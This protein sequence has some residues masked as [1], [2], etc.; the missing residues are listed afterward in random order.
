MDFGNLHFG[1]VTERLDLVADPVRSALP[2]GSADGV[3]GAEIDPE[4]A[5]TAAFCERYAVGMH[6][7]ANCV[8]IEAKRGDTI[9]HA[10]CMILSSDRIDVNG[11]VRKL[12]EAK[13][14]SFTSMDHALSASGM[15]Y[16]GITPIGLPAEWPLLVDEAVAAG[17]WLVIGS[18]IRGSKLLVTGRFLA[19]LPNAQV[20]PIAKHPVPLQA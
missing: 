14:A 13:K 12:L 7:G 11:A 15:E 19:S 20:V 17:E 18:G 2:T 1:P 4:V 9:R 6:Q 3:L 10:A 5:D 16:G 8:V